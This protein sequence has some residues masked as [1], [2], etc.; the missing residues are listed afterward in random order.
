[1]AEEDKD[2]SGAVKMGQAIKTSTFAMKLNLEETDNLAEFERSDLDDS[3]KETLV[4]HASALQAGRTDIRFKKDFPVVDGVEEFSGTTP[5][6][7]TVAFNPAGSVESWTTKEMENAGQQEAVAV[8][9]NNSRPGTIEVSVK[10]GKSSIPGDNWNE[11]LGDVERERGKSKLGQAIIQRIAGSAN[12]NPDSPA[13][14]Q[15][16]KVKEE[17]SSVGTFFINRQLGAHLPQN[18]PNV[19]GEEPGKVNIETLKSIGLLMMM[20]STGDY[21]VPDNP[22]D[23]LQGIA[24]KAQSLVPGTARIGMRVPTSRFGGTEILEQ[25]SDDYKRP[26]GGNIDL[27]GPRMLS[28]GSV[29]NPLVPFDGLS[30]VSSRAAATLLSL[31]VTGLLKAYAATFKRVFR[32]PIVAI[33][34]SVGQDRSTN[35]GL[36]IRGEWTSFSQHR[37]TDYGSGERVPF[38]IKTEFDFENALNRG[39]QVMFNT[40]DTPAQT[41]INAVAGIGGTGVIAQSSG[42]YLTLLREIIRSTNEIIAFGLPSFVSNVNQVLATKGVSIENVIDRLAGDIQSPDL[43]L[44]GNISSAISLIEQ[45]NSTIVNSKLTKIINIIASIGDISLSAEQVGGSSVIDAID[46]QDPA[47]PGFP[48][49]AQLVSKNRLSD[50]VT[51]R[52]GRTAWSGNNTPSRYIIPNAVVNGSALYSNGRE[53]GVRAALNNLG[54]NAILSDTGRLTAEEVR[55]FENDLDASYVPFYFHDLRTNEIISFHAFIEDISDS[56]RADIVENESYGRMGNVLTHKNFSRDLSVTFKAVAT[57]KEDFDLMWFKINK[58][59]TMMQPQYTRGRQLEYGN[60][61]FIQPFSQVPAASPLIRLRVG[62]L[63]T[64]NFSDFD[65]ARQ[66]GVTSADF[67]PGSDEGDLPESDRFNEEYQRIETRMRQGEWNVGDQ[68]IL[69]PGTIVSDEIASYAYPSFERAQVL[70][71]GEKLRIFVTLSD[72]QTATFYVSPFNLTLSREYITARANRNVQAAI[73]GERNN[74]QQEAMSRFFG[75]DNPIVRSFASVRGQGLPGM[76]SDITID[77]EDGTWELDYG[78]RAPKV[79]SIQLSFMPIFEINPGLDADG[80][81]QGAVYNVGDIMNGL[82]RTGATD[83]WS[84]E[85]YRTMLGAAKASLAFSKRRRGTPP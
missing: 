53:D 45:A 43:G 55:E 47:Q 39:F 84:S 7:E 83:P 3:V 46:D 11:L 19:A 64:T 16:S 58:L 28:Y 81:M 37:T 41:F 76:I 42:Y 15:D 22:T 52:S 5:E 8:F 14:N 34:Q 10:K 2:F 70:E 51:F 12:F 20:N 33:G 85:R 30:P 26:S 18:W 38:I 27:A 6:G 9:E 13:I 80:F 49:L 57:S 79:L 71:V 74:Q 48:N 82:K 23:I 73:D 40:G 60:E 31:T 1:M 36:P 62:D 29:N 59:L 61:K 4:T 32:L 78:S 63:I 66:F 50:N 25:I 24:A 56:F 65:L 68:C 44:A 17:D 77:G 69:S 72:G 35:S 21:Y 54:T 67:N 75:S